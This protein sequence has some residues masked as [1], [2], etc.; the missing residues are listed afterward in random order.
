MGFGM[1]EPN[2]RELDATCSLPPGSASVPARKGVFASVWRWLWHSIESRSST[3]S[4]ADQALVSG[5]SFIT[6][7]VVAKRCDSLGIAVYFLSLSISG[8]LVEF[9]GDLVITPYG[10]FR[11]RVRHGRLRRYVG[12]TFAQQSFHV[13]IAGVSLATVAVA[14]Q[15]AGVPEFCGPVLVVA[16]TAPFIVLRQTLR[17]MSLADLQPG[18]AVLMD[19]GASTFQLATLV[20]LA[21]IGWMTGSLAFAVIGLANGLAVAIW[22]FTHRAR[23]EF[24]RRTMGATWSRNHGFGKWTLLSSTLSKV[25]VEFM[26][27]WLFWCHG[28]Q[29]TALW[30]LCLTLMGV[31]AMVLEGLAASVRPII[32]RHTHL[33]ESGRLRHLLQITAVVFAIPPLGVGVTVLLA[34]EWLGSFIYGAKAAGCGWILATLSINS[35][36]A[37]L[38]LVCVVGIL[39]LGRPRDTVWPN[40]VRLLLSIAVGLLAIPAWGPVGAAIATSVAGAGTTLTRLIILRTRLAECQTVGEVV[41]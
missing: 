24:C 33:R 9:L 11:Q 31:P 23:L 15:L 12:A 6:S 18:M 34:G 40:G 16:V 41:R 14:L 2:P 35:L 21:S 4:L 30:G 29:A 37:S 36:A 5:T 3:V 7:V 13:L 22:W 28:E 1:I 25:A 32:F 10:L 19:L 27:W 20:Y 38:G 39:A 26:P 8:L 17:Q